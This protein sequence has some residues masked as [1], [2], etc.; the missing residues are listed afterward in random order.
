[1][2]R[3]ESNQTNA[4]APLVFSPRQQ[5]ILALVARGLTSKVIGR[6]LGISAR[7]VETHLERMRHR[8]CAKTTAH[9]LAVVLHRTE[10][11]R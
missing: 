10:I 8:V 4:L 2:D 7:T 6:E 9:L 1:M 3:L 11:S 5:L